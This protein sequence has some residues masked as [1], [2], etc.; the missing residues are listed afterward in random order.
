MQTMRMA[1][2]L[3]V[4]MNYVRSLQNQIMTL[5]YYSP[6]KLEIM[7]QLIGADTNCKTVID[8]TL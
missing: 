2:M 7:L 4:M 5:I 1:V 6:D 3:D 8:L